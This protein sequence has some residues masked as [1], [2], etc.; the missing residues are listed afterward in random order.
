MNLKPFIFLALL[1]ILTKGCHNNAIIDDSVSCTEAA[2]PW[3]IASYP[4]NTDY[5]QYDAQFINSLGFSV[6]GT[7]TILKTNNSGEHWQVLHDINSE[8]LLTKL[9]LKTL[10][11]IDETTG[12]IGGENFKL[13]FDYESDLGA[14]LLKT[15]NAG[16]TWD[17]LYFSDIKAFWDIHF[18]S[19]SEGIAI[20]QYY[21]RL[22]D[23]RYTL[24]KTY[25]GGKTWNHLSIDPLKL[26][27]PYYHQLNTPKIICQFKD[28]PRTLAISALNINGT[29]D[30]KELPKPAH[31][32]NFID[33]LRGEQGVEILLYGNI[34]NTFSTYISSDSWST[35]I[36]GD[37]NIY[38]QKSI[39]HFNSD[40]TGICISGIYNLTNHSTT[41]FYL[42]LTG[43]NIKHSS[44][45]GLSWDLKHTS[46]LNC[47]F[48]GKKIYMSNNSFGILGS[49]FT[50]ISLN[51]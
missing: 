19:K 42:S 24:I 35:W 23:E 48:I 38:P 47:D 49:N 15:T 3:Q 27:E 17:K 45:L 46:R 10:H 6:G 4:L 26:I 50:L 25:D 37:N 8:P 28:S 32:E 14:I 31:N 40:S 21:E 29:Y 39:I 43:F 41:E 11:F 20:V 44:D 5:L 33:L 1:S 51:Q 12:F 34:F 16:L 18:F 7:G 13:G 9:A 36:K 22:N 2:S 30:I